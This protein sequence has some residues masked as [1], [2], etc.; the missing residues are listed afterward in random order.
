MNSDSTLR[1]FSV[2]QLSDMVGGDVQDVADACAYLAA[3]SGK[4]ITGEVLTVDGGQQM[5]GDPWPT[6]RPA[7]F[8]L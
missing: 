6:G 4:F 8:R 1:G 2:R 5:W 7:Y 3:S